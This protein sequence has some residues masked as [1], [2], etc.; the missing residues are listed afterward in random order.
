MVANAKGGLWPN[1]KKGNSNRPDLTG[2]FTVTKE[3]L[4]AYL[5]KIGRDAELKV[6]ISAWTKQG[7]KGKYLSLSVNAPYDKPSRASS[8][9]RNDDE[10]A[11]F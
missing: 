7:E 1:D 4:E 2:N 3:L 9:R 6:Q 10:D 5:D 8:G 11:P